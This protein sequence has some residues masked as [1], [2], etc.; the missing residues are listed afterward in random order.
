MAAA[1]AVFP[2]RGDGNHCLLAISEPHRTTAVWRLQKD[3]DILALREFLADAQPRAPPVARYNRPVTD[4][5]PRGDQ[6]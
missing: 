4:S 6:Q 2:D 3:L 1:A 5:D